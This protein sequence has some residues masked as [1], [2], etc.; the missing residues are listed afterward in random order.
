MRRPETAILPTVPVSWVL[1]PDAKILD[2]LLLL[3]HLRSF[4]HILQGKS[5]DAPH[6][7]NLDGIAVAAFPI[8]GFFRSIAALLRGWTLLKL[9]P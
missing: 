5:L 1:P 4:R 9:Q 7:G 8:A 3:D 6:A 2:H